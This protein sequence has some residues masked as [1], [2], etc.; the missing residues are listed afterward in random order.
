MLKVDPQN[1][2]AIAGLAKAHIAAGNWLQAK[3]RLEKGGL[4]ANVVRVAP[5]MLVTAA[6]VDEAAEKLDR[7]FRD[8]S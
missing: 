3:N 6:E 8:V 5:S 2:Y 4:Y 1:P 7:A